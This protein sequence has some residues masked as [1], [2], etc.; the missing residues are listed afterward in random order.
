MPVFPPYTLQLQRIYNSSKDTPSAVLSAV[1]ASSTPVCPE[2]D[3]AHI[4]QDQGQLH[5]YPSL[6]P[7]M[8]EKSLVESFDA[9]FAE[10]SLTASFDKPFLD[11]E[12]VPAETKIDSPGGLSTKKWNAPGSYF[13]EEDPAEKDQDILTGEKAKTQTS[14]VVATST[15]PETY[16]DK[17]RLDKGDKGG[18]AGKTLYPL[19]SS[20][21]MGQ[22]AS[23]L[24][25][26]LEPRLWLRL[27]MT[28]EG[29][30]A[31]YYGVAPDVTRMMLEHLPCYCRSVPP[32][33]RMDASV[34]V[35]MMVS[36]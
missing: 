33:P 10:E 3:L 9:A 16:T 26:N 18:S 21:P 13:G 25:N 1:L 15:E 24:A 22:A 31:A 6:I 8:P 2:T 34:N 11:R 20:S 12:D 19:S 27:K 23:R 28:D 32:I 36:P 35:S 29:R 14:D 30:I 4:S 5:P 17:S 7:T